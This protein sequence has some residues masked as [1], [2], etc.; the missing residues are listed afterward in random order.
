MSIVNDKKSIINEVGVLNS[1]GKTAE[2]PNQNFTFPS[3]NTKNEPIPY[4]L[5]LL[6]T[7][8][9]SEALKRTTGQ[10]MT[11]FIRKIEPDLKNNLKKQSVTFNSDKQ[12]PAGFV[13]G[14]QIPTKKVDLF[15]KLKTDPSSAQGSLLYQDNTNSFDKKAYSAIINPNTDVVFGNL[16]LNYSDLTDNMKITPVNSSDTIGS[17]VNTYI[18]NMKI[19][20]EKEFTSQVMDTMYG[21]LSKQSK[22]PLN[23]LVEEEKIRNLINKL[24]ENDDFASITDEELEEIQR[25]AK[26]KFNGVVPID[27][28]CSIID[29]VLLLS[30]IENLIANNTGNTDPVSVGEAYETVMNNTF[31][32]VPEQ[33]NPAN[34]NAI[35]DGYFKRLIKTITDAIVVALTSTPQIR[36]LLAIIN[37]F[38]NNDNVTFPSNSVDD[39][40]SNKNYVNCI[41]KAAGGL[42]NEFIFNLL[43]TELLKIIIPVATLIVK[44]KLQAFIRII[45]S[46]F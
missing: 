42:I 8:I 28:G 5:D 37:G 12:L 46:L 22:K 6:T 36:V 15:N 45:Q 44:E 41:G 31:G 39:M 2:L 4:M 9:G 20:D 27:V 24:V 43:K 35:R 7:T 14:Y 30:D 3:V 26:N 1:I 19:I 38:K 33:T 17:F 11:N 40:N 29:S 21:T 23:S 34:K 13:T 32:R 18:D 10:V 16:K 25:L